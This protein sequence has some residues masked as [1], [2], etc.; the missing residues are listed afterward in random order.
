MN[1]IPRIL[2][3]ERAF[4]SLAANSG[5]KL[6]LRA[7]ENPVE[8]MM[9]LVSKVSRPGELVLDTCARTFV[10]AKSC[11]L[12]PTHRRLVG[13][14]KNSDCFQDAL[15]SLVKAYAKRVFNTESDIG[16]ARKWSLQEKCLCRRWQPSRQEVG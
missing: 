10:I 11:L 1:N 5:K 6:M 13:C 16:G 8:W 9:D 2:P 3:K 4:H 15:P 12:L 14:E 7:E